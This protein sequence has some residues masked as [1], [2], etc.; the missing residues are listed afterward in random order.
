MVVVLKDE[1][2][3]PFILHLFEVKWGEGEIGGDD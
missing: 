2:T 1:R 3:V